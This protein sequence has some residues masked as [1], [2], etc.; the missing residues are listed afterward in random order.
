MQM[1]TVGMEWPVCLGLAVA[2]LAAGAVLFFTEKKRPRAMVKLGICVFFSCV[3]ISFP[4]FLSEEGWGGRIFYAALK[5]ISHAIRMFVVDTAVTDVTGPLEELVKK[6]AQAAPW[7]FYAYKVMASLLY[8]GAPLF[9]LSFILQHVSSMLGRRSVG[10]HRWRGHD[11]YY[12]SGLTQRS[13]VTARNVRKMAE[14]TGKKAV[15]VFCGSRE[16]AEENT[17]L[18]ESAGE[19]GAVFVDRDMEHLAEKSRAKGLSAYF[20]ISDSDDENLR[21]T[22]DLLH[23]LKNPKRR[24]LPLCGKE[25]DTEIYCYAETTEAE[26]LID[27]ED[28]GDIRVL[29]VDETREAV[30][31][32]L[33]EHPLYAGLAPGRED[34]ICLLL[35]GCGKTGMEFL[36]AAV[37]CGQMSGIG[38]EIHVIDIKGNLARKKLEMNLPE[39]MKCGYDIRVE[40]G[41][42][43]SAPA[44]AW[45]DSF[46]DRVTGCLVALG[47]DEENIRAS[48]YLRRY[49][50][51]RSAAP[52]PQIWTRTFSEERTGAVWAMHE[53]MNIE[54][55]EGQ[56]LYYG[57]TPLLAEGQIFDSREE[58]FLLEYLGLGVHLSYSLNRSTSF[59]D[60]LRAYFDRQEFRRSS[61]ASGLHLRYKLWQLGL[62]IVR[63]PENEQDN[64]RKHCMGKKKDAGKARA[65]FTACIHPVSYA[66]IPLEERAPL[67]DLEHERWMA[68]TR[69]N[70]WQLAAAPQGDESTKAVMTAWKGYHGQFRNQNYLLRLHPAL[71]PKRDPDPEKADL[72]KLDQAMP[73]YDPKTGGG[74]VE[75]D[76][77]IV[78]RGGDII[79]GK[80]FRDLEKASVM[81]RLLLPDQ[82]VIAKLSDIAQYEWKLLE[83]AEK[84]SGAERGRQF[85]THM[86]ML[87]SSCRGA[88]R[89]ARCTEEEKNA[90]LDLLRQADEKEG[91]TEK[92]RILR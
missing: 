4:A 47:S 77:K 73:A 85:Q 66:D 26:T 8:I 10:W 75:N 78:D 25:G 51:R 71:V 14:K 45:L 90:C 54:P 12:F 11:L 19:M 18:F 42:I 84:L 79:G 86:E 91:R 1:K 20:E 52:A 13:L 5:S 34:K 35:A 2:A 67:Y 70:G 87:R 59:A 53:K 41:N 37:W 61:I 83:E 28:K 89:S 9:A 46:A 29:V 15:L 36:K 32:C 63:V 44:E 58:G 30:Y 65:L 27:G 60:A 74:Y 62:G 43:F 38:L 49:F 50:G 80:W 33:S 69:S 7:L 72:Y 82:F 31:R 6:G 48:L 56:P 64:A 81:G 57:I 16:K 3:F 92:E 17:E 22:I 24:F 40:K 88:L 39:L 76:R 23:R 55:H 21:N 68:F